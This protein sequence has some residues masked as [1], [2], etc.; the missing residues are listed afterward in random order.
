M[1]FKH[2]MFPDF[3]VL[4]ITCALLSSCSNREYGWEKT[5]P[6]AQ[7]VDLRPLFAKFH[8]QLANADDRAKVLGLIGT[9]EEI[10]GIDPMNYEALWQLGR[11]YLL[12]ADAYAEGSEEKKKSY[13]KGRLACERALYRNPGF[14]KL[15]DAG[16][17]P[18][19]AC[20]ALGAGEIEA[21][22]YWYNNMGGE[23]TFCMN[24]IQKLMSLGRARGCRN[25]LALMIKAD[26]E[27]GGGHPYCAWATYYASIP[28]LFGRDLKK[29][30]EYFDRAVK[31]GPNW[32][33]IKYCRA[34][35]L[36]TR[37][38]NR[39]GFKK[40]LEWVISRDPRRADSPYPWNVHFQRHA[41]QMLAHID[42]YF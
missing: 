35:Y 25:L 41:R 32:L 23:F 42:D 6:P 15:I 30:G 34:R 26:P 27:W 11:Y 9:L 16:K 22:Y 4:F 24:G 7:K 1:S 31:A 3:F 28:K 40:D 10:T 29:S 39:E 5:G 17:D 38:K 8:R 2:I 20:K 19:E 12:M 33:Y 14:R 13:T 21:M 18:F 36:H 37:T